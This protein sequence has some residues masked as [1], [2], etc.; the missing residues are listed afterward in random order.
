[1]IHA[2]LRCFFTLS[3]T[4]VLVISSLYTASALGQTS[5]TVDLFIVERPS[6]LTIYNKYQ[7]EVSFEEGKIFQPYIPMEIVKRDALLSDNFTHCMIVRIRNNMFYLLKEDEKTLAQIDKAGFNAFLSRCSVIS[8]TVR[9]LQDEAVLLSKRLT[10]AIL[11]D[12]LTADTLVR[13]LYLK[14]GRY[15]TEELGGAETYGWS[16]FS[17]RT[18]GRTWDIFERSKA[19]LSEIL[20]PDLRARIE[21]H[22]QDVNTVLDDLFMTLNQETGQTLAAPQWQMV[23]EEDQILCRLNESTFADQFVG[24]AQYIVNDLDALVRREG[25]SVKYINRHI[26]ISKKP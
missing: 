13:R 16:R 11:P 24:S 6:A 4:V 18:R 1:M 10:S 8:D 9:I 5:V 15:Y 20:S 22:L 26:V 3:Y 25:L 23:V 12:S 17:S 19:S 14:N 2:F 7:Q 21:A